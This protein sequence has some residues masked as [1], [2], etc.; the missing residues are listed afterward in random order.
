MKKQEYLN[1]SLCSFQPFTNKNK[2]RQIQSKYNEI[3]NKNKRG[4]NKNKKV[5]RGNK[6]VEIINKK[7][8]NEINDKNKL[9]S[10]QDIV[11]EKKAISKDI[12]EP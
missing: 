12:N 9:K 11:N 3:D 2:Y 10:K 6:S 8:I 4:K 5:H 1:K 7:E